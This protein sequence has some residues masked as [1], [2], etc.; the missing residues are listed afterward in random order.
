MSAKNESRG[1]FN[2]SV[3]F[4]AA[5]SRDVSEV[6]GLIAM[7]FGQ[8]DIDRYTVVYKKDHGPS[9][10]EIHARRNGE[11]WNEEKAKEYAQKVCNL[12]DLNVAA[13]TGI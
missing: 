4:I 5:G 6:G 9:E 2:L 13:S 3:F 10:D 1:L 12:I 11:E 7:S 8:E